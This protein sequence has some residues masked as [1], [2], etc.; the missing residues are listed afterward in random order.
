MEPISLL[1][2]HSKHLPSRRRGSSAGVGTMCVQQAAGCA[3][4]EDGKPHYRVLTRDVLHCLWPRGAGLSSLPTLHSKHFHSRCRRQKRCRLHGVFSC[5]G[6]PLVGCGWSVGHPVT[7]VPMGFVL[8]AVLLVGLW[9][10]S[11]VL[12]LPVK[13]LTS[14][15]RGSNID[16]WHGVLLILFE[17]WGVT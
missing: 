17:M 4:V 12:A 14:R 15:C 8:L 13:R 10:F 5:D 1:S 11:N 16:A 6:R 9:G 7:E 2:L 3:G